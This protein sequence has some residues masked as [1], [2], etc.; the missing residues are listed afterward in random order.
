MSTKTADWKYLLLMCLLFKILIWKPTLWRLKDL[1]SPTWGVVY[2]WR[3]TKIIVGRGAVWTPS[4]HD[5]S[6][7]ILVA[8]WSRPKVE[9]RLTSTSQQSGNRCSVMAK[10]SCYHPAKNLTWTGSR[11][12]FWISCLFNISWNP[13][14]PLL[15]FPPISNLSRKRG[16]SDKNFATTSKLARDVVKSSWC[17]SS[18]KCHLKLKKSRFCRRVDTAASVDLHHGHVLRSNEGL[19]PSLS[20]AECWLLYDFFIPCA[21]LH[22]TSSISTLLSLFSH[23]DYLTCIFFPVFDESQSRSLMFL[24]P[25][26]NRI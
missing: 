11:C 8:T 10:A 1:S 6:L 14:Q 17:D 23:C 9:R 25:G 2:P 24:R 13:P 18:W 16:N 4:P 21:H 12:K 22:S 7:S 26:F 5:S 3:P 20:S 15:T 19:L